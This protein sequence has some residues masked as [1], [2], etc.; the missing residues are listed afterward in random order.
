MLDNCEHLLDGAAA[1]AGT[2]QRSCP[3]LVILATSR[4]AL[5]IEG[6][7]VVPVP[8]LVVPGVDAGPDTVIG[9]GGGAAVR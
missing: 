9:G 7:Q 4:E 2:L 1:L 5:A 6:E 8:P 3:R